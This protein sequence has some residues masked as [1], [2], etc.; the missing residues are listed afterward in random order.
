MGEGEKK[1]FLAHCPA[2]FYIT[3]AFILPPIPLITIYELYLRAQFRSHFSFFKPKVLT[4][5]V[6]TAFAHHRLSEN[7][8]GAGIA[9]A[10]NASGFWLLPGGGAGHSYLDQ[11]VAL[12]ANSA[13]NPSWDVLPVDGKAGVS[14]REH[15]LGQRRKCQATV[16]T[17][18]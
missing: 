18:R 2:A 7:G 13:A 12:Q 3:K 5:N 15:G 9:K 4:R 14:I 11:V 17:S 10:G 1:A 6:N 8:K 16:C